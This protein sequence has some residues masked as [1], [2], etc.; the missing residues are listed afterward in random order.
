MFS[1]RP[2]WTSSLQRKLQGLLAPRH[3][4][5][6]ALDA[7]ADRFKHFVPE[8][9][10]IGRYDPDQGSL[11]FP[12]DGKIHRPPDPRVFRNA[13]NLAAI[14]KNR[15]N[16]EAVLRMEPGEGYLD[17]LRVIM[18]RRT[19]KKQL[20]GTWRP[21]T[22]V[23]R[24]MLHHAAFMEDCGVVEPAG[25]EASNMP[26]FTTPK[27]DLDLRLIQDGRW[28][29]GFFAKP[30][31][32]FLPKIHEVIDKIL[33]AAYVAD[34]D[35][36]SYFYQI[37]LDESVR[38]YFGCRLAGGRG[39]YRQMRFCS[40][41]MGFSWA[42]CIAQRIANTLIADHGV[43]WVDNF[44]VL[45]TSTENFEE[46][47]KSFLQRVAAANLLLDDHVMAPKTNL[48]ALGIEYDLCEKR[49]RMSPDWAL[50][51]AIRLTE[52]IKTPDTTPAEVYTAAGTIVWHSHV[53]RRR[54]C[55]LP[56]LFA[57]ISRLASQ[58]G[59][60]MIDWNTKLTWPEGVA[61]EITEHVET[62]RVN[63]WI[64]KPEKCEETSEVWSDASSTHWSFLAY[65]HDVLLQAN[66]GPVREN[67]HIFLCELSAAM[68]GLMA[69]YRKG[70]KKGILVNVDNTA[71]AIALQRG[72]STN[73]VAN[74]WMSQLPEDLEFRVKWVS[75]RIELADNFTRIAPGH[76]HPPAVPPG[77]VDNIQPSAPSGEIR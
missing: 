50:K 72:I 31:E 55:Q 42:P 69:L 75:T 65:H 39:L 57:M 56:H 77:R 73:R 27:K 3:P 67:M 74:E 62:L 35:G 26:V 58:V 6:A 64:P 36:V 45:G 47:R 20:A 29:N 46:H 5:K 21:C 12:L 8:P 28:N 41:P 52:L 34:A 1:T 15:L 54:L 30:P 16:L 71:A 51:A 14:T 59:S 61:K 38:D 17:P 10:V 23:S 22:K 25:P 2:H 68:G 48:V 76:R 37:P 9:D 44:F 40:L 43:A 4:S 63:A 32:M 19:F 18:S 11:S 70:I 53:T 7:Y 49:Y 24:Y 13:G 66:Q 33:S 60:R